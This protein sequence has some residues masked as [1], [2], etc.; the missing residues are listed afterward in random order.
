MNGREG[1][2]EEDLCIGAKSQVENGVASEGGEI[3]LLRAAWDDTHA[4]RYQW[5][6]TFQSGVTVRHNGCTI[7]RQ[8]RYHSPPI[9]TLCS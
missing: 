8:S 6:I 9:T 3:K 4:G 1:T 2:K 7:C 5:I